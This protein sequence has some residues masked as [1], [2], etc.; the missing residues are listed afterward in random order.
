[1]AE[2]ILVKEPLSR[3][4]I[5]SGAE[6]L[7]RLND[8]GLVVEAAFWLYYSES[9]KWKLQL[10]SLSVDTE[11]QKGAYGKIWDVLYGRPDGVSGIE[12]TDTVVLSPT[13]PLVMAIAGANAIH[14]L[15]SRRMSRANFA[16]TYVEDMYVYFI[17]PTIRAYVSSFS[18][19]R[20]QNPHE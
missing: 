19:E 9:N 7:R 5:E 2:E 6:L 1:M 18:Y 13:E 3:E 11:G 17:N 12:S 16:G 20:P 14:D 15:T 8:V 4:M 10:V